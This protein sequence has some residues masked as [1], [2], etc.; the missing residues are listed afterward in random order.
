MMGTCLQLLQCKWQLCPMSDTGTVS[1][2]SWPVAYR[3][4]NDYSVQ[5]HTS[6]THREAESLWHFANKNSHFHIENWPLI[7]IEEKEKWQTCLF[8]LSFAVITLL[9]KDILYVLPLNVFPMGSS[10]Q[11]LGN[12][13]T[14]MLWK[15]MSF[16]LKVT[17]PNFLTF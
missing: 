13:H 8:V 16:I 4:R 5:W 3:W 10:F 12:I 14:H 9:C 1:I 11:E 2:S 7:Y 17:S 15:G 6:L